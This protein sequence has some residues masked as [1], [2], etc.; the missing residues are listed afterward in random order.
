MPTAALVVFCSYLIVVT[1]LCPR[2]RLFCC[3]QILDRGAQAVAAAATV[4]KQEKNNS[5]VVQWK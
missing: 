3:V 1:S 2:C 4:S 5:A